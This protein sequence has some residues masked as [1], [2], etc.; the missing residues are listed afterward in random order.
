M[1]IGME[2]TK[3][4]EHSEKVAGRVYLPSQNFLTA[5]IQT[6]PPLF[7]HIKSRF[8]GADLQ[9][10]STVLRGTLCVPVQN[11]TSPFIIPSYP[12]VTVT[13]LQEAALS[14]METLIKVLSTTCVVSNK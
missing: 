5:L 13:P 11:D 6:F 1:N 8:V 2:V 3:P 9:K 10:L 4:P 14:A 12:E 7:E